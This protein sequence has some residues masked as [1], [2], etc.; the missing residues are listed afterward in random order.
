VAPDLNSKVVLVVD[1]EMFARLFAVQI[2]LDLGFTVLEAGSAE[3][4]L[5]VL[6]RNDD[7]DLLFTDISMPG[8]MD[9][10]GLVRHVRSVSPDI[11]LLVTSGHAEP[12]ADLLPLGSLFLAKPYTAHAL[13]SAIA[14]A[15][16][17]LER[18]RRR[19]ALMATAP[20]AGRGSR[21]MAGSPIMSVSLLAK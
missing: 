8:D 14:E 13:T 16:E 19:D 12:P 6:D 4:G 9:G 3:E 17:G 10:L 11:A 20:V 18:N 15:A 1:D 2:F 5:D 21:P 7:V